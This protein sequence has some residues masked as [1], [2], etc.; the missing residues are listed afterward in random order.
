METRANVTI[1]H[2]IG[3]V[4][5]FLADVS[6]M[7]A[8]VSGVSSAKYRDGGP[9]EGAIFVVSYTNGWRPDDLELQVTRYEPP[10]HFGMQVVRGPFTFEGHFEL[11][12]TEHGTRVVNVIEAGPDSLAS[13]IAMFVAGGILRRAMVRRLQSELEALRAAISGGSVRTE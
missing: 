13:R 12:E 8:W 7:P 2:P 6:N 10:R 11:E 5:T 1:D 4:F 3:G 9:A